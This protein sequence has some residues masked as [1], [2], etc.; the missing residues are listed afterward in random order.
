MRAHRFSIG[1]GAT[2][3]LVLFLSVMSARAATFTVDST[4]DAVDVNPGDGVCAAASGPCTLRAAIME[5]NA[6][7][8]PDIISFPPLCLSG[9]FDHLPLT[10]P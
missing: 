5:A 4:A 1:L 6:F 2:A 3:A 10:V 9:A 8:G 7:G